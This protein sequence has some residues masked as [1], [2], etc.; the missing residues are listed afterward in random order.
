MSAI[1]L[2]QYRQQ[3]KSLPIADMEQLL[4][5]VQEELRKKKEDAAPLRQNKSAYQAAAVNADG[6]D[7]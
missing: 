3:F 2:S 4:N 5:L 7:I 1:Q 6:W